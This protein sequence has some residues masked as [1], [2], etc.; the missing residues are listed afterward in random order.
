M[1]LRANT[2]ETQEWRQRNQEGLRETP[3][4]GRGVFTEAADAGSLKGSGHSFSQSDRSPDL[5][6][7]D[8]GT[9]P[10]QYSVLKIPWTEESDGLQS[11]GG[12]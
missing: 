10:L 7:E 8:N 4:S 9:L 12:L 6:G 5:L 1:T 2:V 3:D 11:M